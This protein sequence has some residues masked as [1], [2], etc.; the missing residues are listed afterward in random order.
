MSLVSVEEPVAQSWEKNLLTIGWFI[1]IKNILWHDTSATIA[2]KLSV[3]YTC[4][5]WW[6][7][8]RKR[9]KETQF[10]SFVSRVNK[11]LAGARWPNK[12]WMW[13]F[14][15][16][17]FYHWCHQ[18]RITIHLSINFLHFTCKWT[19]CRYTQSSSSKSYYVDYSVLT[20][21]TGS[22]IMVQFLGVLQE[23]KTE[24]RNHTS[25]PESCRFR[26]RGK[27]SP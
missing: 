1:I 25:T 13:M 21:S 10:F 6:A 9:E 14:V 27:N 2:W 20:S 11:G 18:R 26:S 3:L 23:R 24:S 15:Y 12:R 7:K 16:S 8:T 19:E 5:W 4:R 22:Y 17:S